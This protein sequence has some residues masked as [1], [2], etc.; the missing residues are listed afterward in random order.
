MIRKQE[1]ER[2]QAVSGIRKRK[3]HGSRFKSRI[4]LEAVRER[5]TASEIAS[6]SGVHVSQVQKWKKELLDRLPELFENASTRDQSQEK[7][8]EQ[9][10]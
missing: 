8:I 5:K 2:R 4:A 10:Y 7:L 6:G 9:L 3:K 1:T